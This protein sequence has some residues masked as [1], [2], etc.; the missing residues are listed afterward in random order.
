MSCRKSLKVRSGTGL[1]IAGSKFRGWA[2]KGARGGNSWLN[3]LSSAGAWPAAGDLSVI[4]THTEEALHMHTCEPSTEATCCGLQ[5]SAQKGTR[6]GNCT[7]TCSSIPAIET[8][9]IQGFSC[10]K[11]GCIPG[12]CAARCRQ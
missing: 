11:L 6:Q 8:I 5:G 10:M 12:H 2:W 9:M 3:A 4:R 1:G 7:R